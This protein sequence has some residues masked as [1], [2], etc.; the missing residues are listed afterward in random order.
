MFA[1]GA[2]NAV[3]EKILGREKMKFLI[4]DDDPIVL[5]MLSFALKNYFRF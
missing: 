2:N 4:L 3:S 1:G 5:R